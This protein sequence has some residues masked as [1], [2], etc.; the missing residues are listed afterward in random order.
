MKNI[1]SATSSASITGGANQGYSGAVSAPDQTPSESATNRDIP[2]PTQPDLTSSDQ[3]SGD[4][5]DS[6]PHV[7]TLEKTILQQS[8]VG[9]PLPTRLARME[10]KAFGH[11]SNDPDLS[12]RTDALEDYAEQKL[13]KQSP[14]AEADAADAVSSP[15]GQPAAS[16]SDY[17]H[18]TALEKEI[19][20]ETH[21]GQPLTD[22]LGRMESKAFGV[23]SSNPDFSQR[24]DAL[25]AYAEKKL[26]KKPFEQDQQRE[27]ANANPPQKGSGGSGLSK[28]L[29]NVVGNSILGMV[30]LGGGGMGS[31]FGG[32]MGGPGFG[33]GG[34]G[35]GGMG[36]GGTRRR[37]NQ[38]EAPEASVWSNFSRY[39]LAGTSRKIES[40][41]RFRT[42]KVQR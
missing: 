32:G 1:I 40:R 6:Y 30:G 23:P 8:F 17:P 9:Q 19:L 24:T 29:V 34:M 20:G 28:Q 5:S 37:S 26:Y 12:Q 42:R 36:P 2:A 22:R 38:P 35:P 13:H 27:A 14:Q 33:M 31:P 4:I 15:D 11:A 7:T 3:P 41:T 10:T 39:A 25:E 16:G 18:I 21:A